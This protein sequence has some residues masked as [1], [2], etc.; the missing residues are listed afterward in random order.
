MYRLP[1]EAEWEYAARSDTQ[2]PFFFGA[3]AK[4]LCEYGNTPDLSRQQK[5]P[6]WVAVI[7]TDGYADVAPVGRFSANK[8]ALFDTLGNLWEWVEDCWHENYQGAP[9]DGSAWVRDGDCSQRVLRGGSFDHFPLHG[10]FAR[11]RHAA[12]DR[13]GS[14]GFRVARRVPKVA[15]R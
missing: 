14:V 2:S 1:S 13:L 15:A 5:Y 12:N 10:A 11:Y 8:F 4:R 9:Y 3:D 6:N 7:C